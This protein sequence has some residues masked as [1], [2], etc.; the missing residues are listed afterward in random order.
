[1]ESVYF[2][3]FFVNS[4]TFSLACILV[5]GIAS[6]YTQSNLIPLFIAKY[7]ATGESIPPLNISNARGCVPTGYP[8]LPL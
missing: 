3:N 5:W 2:T 7:P 6:K 1:M 8:P 4:I